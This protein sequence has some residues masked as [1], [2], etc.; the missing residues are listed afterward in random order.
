MMEQLKL[1]ADWGK[2]K[3]YLNSILRNANLSRKNPNI[4]YT[5]D[6][7]WSYYGERPMNWKIII[8]K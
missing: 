8:T 6:T 5:D 4:G 3:T 1:S 7:A 2:A